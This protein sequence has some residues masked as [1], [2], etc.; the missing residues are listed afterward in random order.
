MM[1]NGRALPLSPWMILLLLAAAGCGDIHSEPGQAV[2]HTLPPI[3]SN[4]DSATAGV[5]E[6]RVTWDGDA[7]AVPPFEP[8]ATRIV[9]P[10]PAPRAPAGVE[11]RPR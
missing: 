9:P 7:P 11:E 8:G 1:H 3:G 2:D 10:A 6:G 4:F 5:I